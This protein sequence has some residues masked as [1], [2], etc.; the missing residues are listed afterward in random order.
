MDHIR[1]YDARQQMAERTRRRSGRAEAR[2][3]APE[4]HRTP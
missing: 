3:Q 1:R 2:E 4:A